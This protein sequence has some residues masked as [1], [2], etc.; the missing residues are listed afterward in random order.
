MTESKSQPIVPGG[1]LFKLASD[2]SPWRLCKYWI[3][4]TQKYSLYKVIEVYDE[5]TR[6]LHRF[7]TVA[8]AARFY[9]LKPT[10]LNERLNSRGI[11]AYHDGTRWARFPLLSKFFNEPPESNLRQISL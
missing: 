5:N 10:T 6:I 3:E 9:N 4:L 1:Y 7:E 11:T 2:P 8:K